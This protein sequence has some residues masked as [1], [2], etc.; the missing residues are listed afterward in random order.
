MGE[1]GIKLKGTLF[2]HVF[3]Y[4]FMLQRGWEVIIH[5]TIVSAGFDKM[6]AGSTNECLRCPFFLSSS[7]VCCREM[8]SEGTIS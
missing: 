4:V 1:F 8:D 3:I 2:L 5:S 7:Y 6:A